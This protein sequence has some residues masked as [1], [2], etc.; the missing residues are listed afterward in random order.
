MHKALLKYFDFYQTHFR[1]MLQT[2]IKLLKSRIHPVFMQK[3]T[4]KVTAVNK[5]ALVSLITHFLVGLIMCLFE[6]N[7]AWSEEIPTFHTSKSHSF[8]ILCASL[9]LV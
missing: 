4:T 6:S 9:P 7:P 3:I 5:L 8:H 2:E 1:D